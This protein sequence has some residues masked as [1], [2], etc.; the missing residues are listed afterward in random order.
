MAPELHLLQKDRRQYL[1]NPLIGY[2]NIN[3]VRNKMAD[4]QI[5]I[6]NITLDYFVLSET[7]LDECFPNAQFNLD[8]YKIRAKRDRDKNG[9]GLIEFVRRGII[10]KR[11]SDFKLSFSECICSELTISKSRWLCFSMHRPP[12]PSKLSIAFE[13]LSESLSK[14]ILKYQSIIIMGDFN[15]D[16]KIK[17]IGFNKLDEFCDLFNLTNLIKTETCF[18]K[19]HKSHIDFFLTNKPLSFQKTHVTET[20]LNDYHKLISTFF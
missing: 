14:A 9:G 1:N 5:I 10:Y 7:K 20:G 3:S 11:I 19:S 12:D 4:L 18:T 16:Q 6:Q 13:E 17:V 2:L 15:I 8:G